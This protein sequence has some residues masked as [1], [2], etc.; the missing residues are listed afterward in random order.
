MILLTGITGKSGRWF[1]EALDKDCG[2]LKQEEF[3]AVVR[4]SSNLSKLNE[5]QLSVEKKFGDLEDGEFLDEVM[6]GVDTVFHIAGIKFSRKVVNAAIKN[7]VKWI[8]CVH[9]TGMYSKYKSASEGYVKIENEINQITE[10]SGVS[11]TILRPTMIYGSVEDRNV[12]VFIKMVKRLKLFPVVNNARYL[13]QPVHEKDLGR[14]YYQVLLNEDTTMG[15]NYNLSGKSPILLIDMLK[16]I[17]KCMD[18]ENIFVSV[19][20]SLAYTGAW[21]LYFL[22]ICRVDYREKVQRLV[23]PRVFSH[24]EATQDFGYDP[25]SFEEGI[26]NEVEEYLELMK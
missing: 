12:I 9:T 23:E 6:K 3:R 2:E 21:G 18:R 24:E 1:L 25:I 4:K 26:V 8:V 22:T 14:A 13:L 10:R 20:F 16:A 7:K 11:T 5:C 15:R 19:P 17:G